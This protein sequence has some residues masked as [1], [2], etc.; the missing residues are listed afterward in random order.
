[1]YLNDISSLPKDIVSL[2]YLIYL[3]FVLTS[4]FA[5]RHGH[6]VLIIAFTLLAVSIEQA[7]IQLASTHCHA[8]A[9]VMLSK[10]SSLNSILFY[11]PWIYLSLFAAP[12]FRL[13]WWATPSAVAL[14]QFLYGIT[15]ELQGPTLKYWRY[16]DDLD[17]AEGALRERWYEMPMMALY[18]HPVM[19]AAIQ[20]AMTCAGYSVAQ[21]QKGFGQYVRMFLALALVVPFAFAFGF[22][23]DT[24][25]RL[26]I[27][28]YFVVPVCCFLLFLLP[29]LLSLPSRGASVTL[30]PL[31]VFDR[32]FALFIVGVWQSYFLSRFH[33]DVRGQLVDDNLHFIL[34]ALS[35]VSVVVFWA[36]FSSAPF[37]MSVEMKK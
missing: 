28:R 7:S 9:L 25:I 37:P 11:A 5:Y 16:T 26:G 24:F 32:S 13:P 6:V 36:A 2:D 14:L 33:F 21:T 29:L 15:Y 8:D 23:V 31:S 35:L 10:C 3:V 20:L 30:R 19:G 27:S 22:P 12:Y 17:T 34:S 1:M 18:F 4:F